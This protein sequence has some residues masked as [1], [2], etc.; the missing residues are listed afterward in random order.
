MAKMRLEDAVE[1]LREVFDDFFADLRS[2]PDEAGLSGESRERAEAELE[3][4]IAEGQAMVEQQIAK[5]RR[6]AFDS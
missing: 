6:R 1:M 4:I 2:A 3:G 5:W